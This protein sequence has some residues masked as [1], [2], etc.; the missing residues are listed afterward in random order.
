MG[1]LGIGFLIA[2]ALSATGD[3]SI[4]AVAKAMMFGL[5]SGNVLG[6]GIYKKVFSNTLTR[7]DMV[8]GAL[9]LILSGVGVLAGLFAMD[10]LGGA[11]G[12][13]VVLFGSYIG[14]LI[15]CATGSKIMVRH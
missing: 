12:I 9:G 10:V 2:S 3:C 6:I 1:G 8:G 13:S 5:P 14:S 15:G 4:G 11:A 7:S